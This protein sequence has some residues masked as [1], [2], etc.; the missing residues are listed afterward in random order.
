MTKWTKKQNT[1]TNKKDQWTINYATHGQLSQEGRQRDF[2]KGKCGTI[3]KRYI[4][5]PRMIA[6]Q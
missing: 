4:T 3:Q 2:N 5:N 1:Y 6:K